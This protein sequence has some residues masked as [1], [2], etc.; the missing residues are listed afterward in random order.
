MIR[1]YASSDGSRQYDRRHRKKAPFMLTIGLPGGMIDTPAALCYAAILDMHRIGMDMKYHSANLLQALGELVTEKTF[2]YPGLTEGYQELDGLIIALQKRLQAF[3]FKEQTQE[4]WVVLLGGT[5]TG[6]SP[7]FNALCGKAL[8]ETG[9]ERPKTRGPVAFAHRPVSSEEEF[10]Y[11]GLPAVQQSLEEA[12]ATPNGG[13]PGKLLVLGHE[14]EEWSHL[15]FVDTPDVDSVEAEN[16]KITE[17]LTLLADVLVFVTIQEKYAD[18]VP[19]RVLIKLLEN[20]G[21]LFSWSTRR[22]K[23]SP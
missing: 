18:E 4:L 13:I 6:K 14:R 19:F 17:D 3:F 2:P 21:L 12:E 20:S 1:Q 22:K 11:P 23:D 9:V 10:L 15:V 7:L 5:G 16:R 8:S